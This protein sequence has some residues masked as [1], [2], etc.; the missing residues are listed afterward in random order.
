MLSVVRCWSWVFGKCLLFVFSPSTDKSNTSFGLIKCC[1]GFKTFQWN[2]RLQAVKR[3]R[4]EIPY[5]S[6]TF[7]CPECPKRYTQSSHLKRHMQHHTGHFSFY[8]QLCKKGFNEKAHFAD[9]MRAH[10]GLKYHCEMCSKPFNTRN[11]YRRHVASHEMWPVVWL[12]KCP[13]FSLLWPNCHFTFWSWFVFWWGLSRLFRL[14]STVILR[15]VWNPVSKVTLSKLRRVV[16]LFLFGSLISNLTFFL[17]V[18]FVNVFRNIF[19]A[20]IR[21]EATQEWRRLRI[22][23]QICLH[24]V[25]EEIHDQRTAQAPHA[26]AH[27]TVQVSLQFL[28]EGIQ[29]ENAFHGSCERPPRPQVLLRALWQSLYQGPNLPSSPVVSLWRHNRQQRAGNVKTENELANES[30][31]EQKLP[32]RPCLGT[33]WSSHSLK[34]SFPLL[35]A[36][37]YSV[38][39]H[40][41][42]KM[43]DCV[44]E[45][46]RDLWR[47]PNVWNPSVNCGGIC[48]FLPR[49]AEA[50][51][52]AA[53]PSLHWNSMVL[54]GNLSFPFTNWQ[55]FS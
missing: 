1:L 13:V 23:T 48:A 15:S 22:S 47:R 32:C 28:Q 5:S 40:L 20:V 8:C 54:F 7:C 4:E 43:S 34:E 37:R 36:L 42:C 2:L 29:W 35:Q 39:A 11:A 50:R 45:L 18:S 46:E 10:N 33:D 21:K 38:S 3:S 41:G 53:V 16:F 55:L 6:R 24:G 9:H 25:W 17:S 51:L 49:K 19:V 26:A 12:S 27:G 52:C 30:F 44:Y 31:S 14:F